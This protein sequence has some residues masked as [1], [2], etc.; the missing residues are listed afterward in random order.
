MVS[1]KLWRDKDIITKNGQGI[2]TVERVKTDTGIYHAV[3]YVMGKP[4]WFMRNATK[5]TGVLDR[6]E[7]LD[8][9][10]GRGSLKDIISFMET[11]LPA[12][13]KK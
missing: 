12:N 10:M 5:Q 13:A 3:I 4:C 6:L 1:F 7:T 9:E 8:I 11:Y 2:L